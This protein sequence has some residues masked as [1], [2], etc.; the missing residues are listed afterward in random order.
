MIWVL[1]FILFVVSFFFSGMEAG[2][3]S[4]NRVRVR[5]QTKIGNE[6]AK[7]LWEMLTHPERLLISVL[8]VTNL[9][10]II[11][12]V[13]LT[14]ELVG[15]LGAIGYFISLGLSIPL[16]LIF[17]EMFPKSLFRRFPYRLLSV[18]ARALWFVN[19]I[20]SPLSNVILWIGKK[21]FSRKAHRVKNIFFVREHFKLLTIDSERLGMLSSEQRQLIHNVVDF[22]GT[23]A[24]HL[25]VEI[26]KVPVIPV[27]MGIE[28]FLSFA[29]VKQFERFPVIDENGKVIGLVQAF[30][31]MNGVKGVS[32]TM[33]HFLRRIVKVNLDAMATDIIHRMRAARVNIAVVMDANSTPVGVVSSEQIISQMILGKNYKPLLTTEYRTTE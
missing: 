33:R 1:I 17:L 10:N 22:R 28:E 7:H 30:D 32:Q 21:S 3:L 8:L 9:T 13:L 2:I 5:H 16:V 23:M 11:I 6:A 4:V 14:R 18:F 20:M 24:K 15:W 12:V 29:E 31:V 27:S 19:V 25:M 26:N